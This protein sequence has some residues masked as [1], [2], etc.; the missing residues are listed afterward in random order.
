MLECDQSWAI[1]HQIGRMRRALYTDI[2][3]GQNDGV[4]IQCEARSVFSELKVQNKK[5]GLIYDHLL[6]DLSTVYDI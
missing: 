4:H 2:R 3:L 6:S 1:R 5:K